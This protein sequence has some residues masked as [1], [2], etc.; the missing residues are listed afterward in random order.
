[1]RDAWKGDK[2]ATTRAEA[3]AGGHSGGGDGGGEGGGSEG[4]GGRAHCSRLASSAVAPADPR[5]GW[6][7]TQH[8]H[9]GSQRHH[10]RA[11]RNIARVCRVV[12]SSRSQCSMIITLTLRRATIQDRPVRCV[13]S[14]SAVG[15]ANLQAN[16]H[17]ACTRAQNKSRKESSSVG[18]PDLQELT[19]VSAAPGESLPPP[20]TAA[21]IPSLAHA[22]VPAPFQVPS[23][24]YPL[25]RLGRARR[26]PRAFDRATCLS[27]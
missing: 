25:R 6:L 14:A 4:A 16:C 23:P 18:T 27:A 2:A 11:G 7:G 8:A 26:P 17:A 13:T 21:A 19:W 5:R 15:G 22:S 9:G 3:R 1:M 24:R 10:I 20:R 12:E